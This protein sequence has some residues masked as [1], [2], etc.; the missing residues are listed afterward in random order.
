MTNEEWNELEALVMKFVRDT[1]KDRRGADDNAAV[2][3]YCQEG[4]P[5]LQGDTAAVKQ[6]VLQLIRS[7][8]RR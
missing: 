8:A 5:G 1:T 2:E 3:Q 4:A 6:L 7:P